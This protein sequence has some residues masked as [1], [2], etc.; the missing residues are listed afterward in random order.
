MGISIPSAVEDNG[1]DGPAQIVSFPVGMDGSD[2]VVT[3]YG[4]RKARPFDTDDHGEQDVKPQP[5]RIPR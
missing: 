1:G 5:L 3:G 2:D 4:P